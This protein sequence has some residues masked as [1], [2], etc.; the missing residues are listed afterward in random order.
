[1]G[2]EEPTTNLLAQID[3]RRRR[4]RRIEVVRRSGG[5]GCPVWFLLVVHSRV[6]D[7][8]SIGEALCLSMG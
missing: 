3:E 4:G 7:V 8:V 5:R 2:M 1:M 6:D